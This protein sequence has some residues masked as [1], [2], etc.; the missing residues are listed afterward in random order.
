MVVIGEITT[1]NPVEMALG[2][3][4][5]VI[6]TLVGPENS[7]GFSKVVMMQPMDRWKLDYLALF[8]WMDR[9]AIG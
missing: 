5:Y 2:E 6:Q 4:N 1:E 8:R 7:C 3:D 9:A